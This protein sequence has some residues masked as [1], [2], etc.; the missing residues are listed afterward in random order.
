MTQTFTIGQA[1]ERTGLSIHTLRFYERENLLISNVARTS[2]GRRR[3]TQTDVE[4]LAICVRLRESGMPL[5]QLAEFAALVR[6][7]PGNENQRLELLRKHEGH[8][9]AQLASL[10]HC[11]DVIEM[12]VAVYEDRVEHA[13]AQGLWDPTAAEH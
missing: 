12:K 8:V 3:Y 11:L 6:Q 7:G 10:Q 5:A 2:S 4:W 1:A 9:R 13:A